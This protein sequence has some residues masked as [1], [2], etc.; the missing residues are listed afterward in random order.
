LSP[1]HADRFLGHDQHGRPQDT[2]CGK[3]GAIDFCRFLELRY[4]GE[5]HELTG[6]SARRSMRST[7]PGHSGDFTCGG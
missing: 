5:L 6:W 4:R 7:V 1:G 2:R 3:A